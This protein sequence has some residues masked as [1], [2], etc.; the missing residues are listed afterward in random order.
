MDTGHQGPGGEAPRPQVGQ[1]LAC[2]EKLLHPAA[3]GRAAA[4]CKLALSDRPFLL[5]SWVGG[6]TGGPIGLCP[7]V[8]LQAFLLLCWCFSSFGS[9]SFFTLLKEKKIP[10]FMGA[11]GGGIG[12][13]TGEA[14]A[15]WLSGLLWE[16]EAGPHVGG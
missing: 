3:G 15:S 12:Q 13:G 14:L 4:D 5:P 6:A 9:I 11:P 1:W 2:S 7:H 16:P 10:I 8:T